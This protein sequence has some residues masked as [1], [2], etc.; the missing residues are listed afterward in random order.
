MNR[1]EEYLSA[2]DQFGEVLTPEQQAAVHQYGEAF[3]LSRQEDSPESYDAAVEAFVN[4]IVLYQIP[5]G[6]I[7]LIQ[8]SDH[9]YGLLR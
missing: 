3:I 2:L 5:I 6:I 4:L 1:E 8:S 7:G 9:A